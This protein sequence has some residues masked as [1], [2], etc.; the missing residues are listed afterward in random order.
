MHA[1][2]YERDSL[3]DRMRGTLGLHR[4]QRPL[5]TLGGEDPGGILTH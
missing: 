5:A 1:S 4:S 2:S 3:P